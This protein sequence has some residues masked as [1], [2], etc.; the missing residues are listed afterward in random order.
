M[1]NI[2]KFAESELARIG[3]GADT[4]D[5]M[6]KAMHDHVMHM[7]EEFSK[8]GHSG[9][10]ASYA[11]GILTKLL[12][13]KPLTPI[14]DEPDEWNDVS[15]DSD[16]IMYQHKRMSSVF[17][18]GENG[19]AYDIDAVIF[20]RGKNGTTFTKGGYRHYIKFP[21][22]QK[23]KVVTIPRWQFWR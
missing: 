18:D 11:L 3:M 6:N 17:K 8:E 16:H 9:F 23:R 13:W 1:S 12:D 22:T 7:V 19:R 5:P 21:Y 15:T 4:K 14:T 2:A 20:R 10:S